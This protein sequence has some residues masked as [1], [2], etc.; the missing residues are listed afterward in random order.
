[1][2][3]MHIS[4]LYRFL[5]YIGDLCVCQGVPIQKVQNMVCDTVL[6][7]ENSDVLMRVR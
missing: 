6:K 4:T 2:C 3:S 1:M 5:T 7:E